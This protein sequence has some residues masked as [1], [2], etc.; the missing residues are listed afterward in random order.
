MKPLDEAVEAVVD[1][2]GIDDAAVAR[3]KA[4]LELTDEDVARLKALHAALQ[5]LAP[6]IAN[7][8]YA[9]LLRFEETRRFLPVETLERLKRTQSAY[10]QSLTAGD[11]GREYIHNRLRVGITHQ[12]IGLALQWYLGAYAKYLVG[13]LPEIRKRLGNDSQTFISTVQALIKVV[14]LDMGLAIDTYVQADRQTILALKE[15][16]EMVFASVPFGL[17][18]LSPELTV[19][20]ANRTFLKQF[21]LTMAT[22]RGRHLMGVIAADGLPE[23]ALQVLESGIAQHDLP[24]RMGPAGSHVRTPVRVTLTGIRLAEEEEEE[25]EARLLVIVEDVSEQERLREQARAHEQRFHDLVQ[26]LDAIVWEADAATFAFTFVSRRAEAILGYPLDRWLAPG[27]LASLIYPED[28]DQ[29]L[30]LYRE[31]TAKGHDHALEYRAVAADGRV[32]WLQDIVHVVRDKEAQAQHLRG[33][34]VD[35]TARKRAEEWQRHYART[36]DLLS[37]GVPLPEVLEGIAAFAER[38]MDGALCSILLLSADGKRLAH[39][40]APS[41]P[42]FYNRALDGLAI[43]EGVGS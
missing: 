25:E 35:I 14:L 43:G 33:V 27:F 10:F 16:A 21:G 15:Y 29:T 31:A 5:D 2:L 7:A 36:L 38:Q 41:L 26:G 40:A 23:R 6:D 37:T 22:V 13:L 17:A 18:V 42:E 30:A 20:S 34:M 19:L 12:R 9:H 4:F 11:Y 8:F 3:R 32:V 39:G 1:M 28:R 24:F